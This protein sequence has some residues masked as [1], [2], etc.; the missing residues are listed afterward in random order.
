M[1]RIGIIGCGKI[2][3]SHAAIIS[4]LPDCEIVGVCDTEELMAFQLSERFNVK[5]YF[6]DAIRFLESCHPDVVH[7]TTPPQSHF[8]L[9][10]LC[11]EMGCHVYV[12]KPFTITASETLTLID[13]A[14]RS[15]LKLTVGTDAQFSP[16]ARR[17]RKLIQQGVLGGSPFHLESY[18]CYDLGNAQYAKSFLGDKNHWVRNL[19]GKLLH[20]I[21]SHGIA[22]IAEFIS[23]D[24]PNVIVHGH[25]SPLLRDINEDDIRDELRVI[26]YDGKN[27]TAYFTFSSQIYPSQQLL[28]LYGPK[29]TLIADDNQQTLLIINHPSYKS[30]LKN[31][32]PQMIYAKQ[33]LESVKA[34]IGAFIRNDF[35]VNSG[36]KYLIRSFYE[37]IN[38]NLDPPIPYRE[39]ILTSEILD[40]IFDRLNHN[41]STMIGTS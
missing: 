33:Y 27:S 32:I 36:M 5:H 10:N 24:N 29:C 12:E 20:N 18:F 16:V 39:I 37:S 13:L 4:E 26:I 31:F 19:P 35:H 11:I 17:M 2:A 38:N 30:Y 14:S 1:L 3:D 21:I 40:L 6:N 22:K 41:R 23:S 9:A 34:N 8:S 15:N 7:I 28:R 25:S